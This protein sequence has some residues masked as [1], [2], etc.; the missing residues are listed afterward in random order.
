MKYIEL[1]LGI[2]KAPPSSDTEQLRIRAIQ[3]MD[4]YSEVPIT[5]E[6]KRELRTNKIPVSDTLIFGET[7]TKDVKRGKNDPNNQGQKVESNLVISK[8]QL[9]NLRIGRTTC[10]LRHAIGSKKRCLFLLNN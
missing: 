6:M 4:K 3:V 8:K 7:L 10:I 2:L 9:K 1:A 5:E